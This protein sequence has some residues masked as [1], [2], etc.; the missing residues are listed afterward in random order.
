MKNL[1]LQNHGDGLWEVEVYERVGA[2]ALFR[3]SH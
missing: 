2:V 3:D 1:T